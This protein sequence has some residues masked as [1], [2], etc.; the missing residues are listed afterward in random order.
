MIKS[1]LLAAAII[2]LLAPAH[3][4]LAKEV[5]RSNAIAKPSTATGAPKKFGFQPII[6]GSGASPKAT[7]TV[8]VHYRGKLP[9]GT[10]FDSSYKRGKPA[11][12][13]LDQVI[14]CWTEG[15][16]LMKPGGKAK[17]ICPADMAYGAQGVPGVIKGGAT[18]IFEVDLVSVSR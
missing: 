8:V 9:D 2:A 18:L 11:K 7:D 10:E 17:L 3:N 4:A 15:L 5:I 13:K 12:F 14:P 6:P 1:S 16:Q